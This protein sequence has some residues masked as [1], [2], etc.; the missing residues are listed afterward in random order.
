MT[1]IR[2]SSLFFVLL[3][4][5]CILRYTLSGVGDSY[6]ACINGLV[7]I[8]ARIGFAFALTAIPVIGVW[9]ICW[10]TGLTWTVTA[11]A[12]C[13]RYKGSRWM[14]KSLIQAHGAA[15]RLL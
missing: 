14:D 6:F 2:I 5:L 11:I 13:F 15:Q 1:G 3:G 7:E 12:S 4:V 10:T 8:A 9:V